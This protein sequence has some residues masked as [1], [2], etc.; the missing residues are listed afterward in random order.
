M[1][2]SALSSRAKVS[3]CG[4]SG[5]RFSSNMLK[6]S[7][8]W[9]MNMSCLERGCF[10]CSFWMTGNRCFNVMRYSCC[11]AE[12]FCQNSSSD[13]ASGPP[14]PEPPPP[15]MVP[16]RP[17]T[18]PGDAPW[19]PLTVLP[20]A[21][22]GRPPP[23]PG[24]GRLPAPP[25]PLVAP[26][27]PPSDGADDAGRPPTGWLLLLCA[28]APKTPLA[29]AA[30]AADEADADEAAAAEAAA[31]AA[32]EAEAEFIPASA[33]WGLVGSLPPF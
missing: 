32:A 33:V 15:D 29:A 8:K 6:Q 22:V 24:G 4:R 10:C 30:A 13:P 23:L 28:P 18:G 31:A 17:N 9:R 3:F 14:G 12:S 1:N 25:S 2:L 26:L 19:L 20:P 21:A 7:L 5:T 16:A 27:A 11:I